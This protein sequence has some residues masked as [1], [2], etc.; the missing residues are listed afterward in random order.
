MTNGEQS[1]ENALLIFKDGMGNYFEI[2]LTSLQEFRM[3]DDSVE[4]FL[5]SVQRTESS[6][7]KSLSA[8]NASSMPVNPSSFVRAVPSS[9]VRAVPSSFVR[10]V[11][12][13][14]VRAVPSSFVRAVPSS[15][16]RAVPSSFVRAVPSSFVRAVPSPGSVNAP[17]IIGGEGSVPSN[18]IVQSWIRNS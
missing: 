17:P 3:S 15:F 11:P 2:P 16:V 4:T 10:A 12:S 14:L 1:T 13:S 8:V 7:A 18:R 9:L 6:G 5:S